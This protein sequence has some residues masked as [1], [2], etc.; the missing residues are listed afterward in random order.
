[1]FRLAKLIDSDKAY[2]LTNALKAK[3][4]TKEM[5]HHNENSKTTIHYVLRTLY[6]IYT[7]L[8][9]VAFTALYKLLLRR[10]EIS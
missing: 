7:L 3:R 10:I 4:K 6:M 9:G 1:M 5:Q 8:S 2:S